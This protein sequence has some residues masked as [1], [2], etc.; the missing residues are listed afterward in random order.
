M[1]RTVLIWSPNPATGAYEPRVKLGSSGGVIGGSVGNSLLG[2][3][4]ARWTAGG[5]GVA[6]VGYGGSINLWYPSSSS[7]GVNHLPPPPTPANTG[8]NDANRTLP[9]LWKLGGTVTGHFR[10]VKDLA[11]DPLGC[12]LLTCGEDQTTRLWSPTLVDGRVGP[13]AELGR[14]QV[15][16]Y[17]VVSL[18]PL[19][20]P[21]H[22]FASGAD[23]K[24]VRLFDAPESAVDRMVKKGG[25]VRG[26]GEDEGIE[27]GR[28]KR[29]YV[30][31]LGLSNRGGDVDRL[32]EEDIEDSDEEDKGEEEGKFIN[33]PG[34]RELGV[35]TLWLEVGKMGGAEGEILTLA[36]NATCDNATRGEKPV[37]LSTNK[38][39]DEKSAVIR[40]WDVE[41]NVCEGVLEGGHKSSV[42]CLGFNREGTK[43][44]S[45]GKDRRLCIWSVKKGEDPGLRVRVDG[46][47]KRIVWCLDWCKGEGEKGKYLATG[48]RDGTVKIWDTST[49]PPETVQTITIGEPVTAMAFGFEPNPNLLA[50]GTESGVISVLE[51]GE[52]FT[53]LKVFI[54]KMPNGHKKTVNKIAF[55]PGQEVP[56]LASCGEDHGVRI[57]SL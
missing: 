45:S 24:F 42:C 37:L 27:G 36:S 22:R 44:A 19:S 55:R 13:W 11:W 47:H 16:G 39:R 28:E 49:S 30:P 23:E 14:P 57:W 29:A 2:Y 31:A 33:L 15:H 48:S 54:D 6:A 25:Y 56:E 35:K 43:V 51:I 50:L 38:A 3:T 9:N 7:D 32:K 12:Y 1:D 26:E 10:P 17:E 52:D 20:H 4:H 18:C 46:A 53:S 5:N 41:T 40:V 21:R 34:E 8:D